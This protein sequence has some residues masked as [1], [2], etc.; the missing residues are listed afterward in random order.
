MTFAERAAVL[1]Y[2]GTNDN[3]EA[4]RKAFATGS[5]QIIV[6]PGRYHVKDVEIPSK[7]KLFGTYSYKPYNVTSDAS[8][9]T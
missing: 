9:G 2:T 8:F 4:F 6:P 5:R 1:N 3:S 7:V